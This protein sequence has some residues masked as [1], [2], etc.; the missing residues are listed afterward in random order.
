M[1]IDSIEAIPFNIPLE[2]PTAFAHAS[3]S[4]AE[5]V[6][7]R[8]TTDDGVVG[9]AEAPARPFTYGESQE[10]IVKAVDAWFSPAMVGTDPFDRE[11]ARNE[12]SW[13]RHN[14]TARGG[15]DMA[16]W[17]VIGKSLGQSCHKLFGGYTDSMEVVHILFAATPEGMVDE[18]RDMRER[19]GFNT[20]KIKTG[21]NVKEDA[22]AM[23]MLRAELGEVPDMYVDANKGWTADETIRLLPVMEEV[24]ITMLEEPTPAFRP[25]ARRRVAEKSSI[26]IM[27][28]ESVTRLGEVGRE[29]LDN[30]SQIISIKVART[31]F[32]ESD[33]I[34]GLCEGLGIGLALGSQMDGTVGTLSSLAFAAAYKSTSDRAGELDYFMQLTDDIV[35]VTPVIENGRMHVSGKPGIGI[36]IDEDKLNHYRIDKD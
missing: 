24:G 16:V 10:S 8:V 28:D 1:K 26:P 2:R 9:H 4:S 6:L 35:A 11:V 36:E 27:G 30:H 25:L 19:F 31:G 14:H 5:H 18:A 21:K 15:V 29:I 20:F 17:D 22:R 3:I 34:V 32:T 13:L 33:R 7:I 23:R 12:L